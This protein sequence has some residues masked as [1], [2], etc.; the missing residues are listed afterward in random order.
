[1]VKCIF[2][3][4]TCDLVLRQSQAAKSGLTRV[5]VWGRSAERWSTCQV[6]SRASSPTLK[7][8]KDKTTTMKFSTAIVLPLLS[9]GSGLAAAASWSFEDA[10]L[11]ISSKGAGVGGALKEK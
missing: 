4:M 2:V 1:M 5:G 10:T 6:A 11:S 7:T 8:T 9:L 3:S